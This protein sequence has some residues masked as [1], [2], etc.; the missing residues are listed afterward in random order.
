MPPF[1]TSKRAILDIEN[2]LGLRSLLTA[3]EPRVRFNEALSEFEREKAFAQTAI[4]TMGF[5]DME[6]KW[7]ST[8]LDYVD[9]KIRDVVS[10]SLIFGPGSERLSAAG[11]RGV[12]MFL[13]H[14]IRDDSSQTFPKPATGASFNEVQTS[15]LYGVARSI[16]RICD[17]AELLYEKEHEAELANCYVPPELL[18]PATHE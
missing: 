15:F 12:L 10:D 16:N 6:A 4:T 17:A 5:N 8:R 18:E 2:K 7:F 14:G 11:P 9:Q 3:A 1:L 13:Q